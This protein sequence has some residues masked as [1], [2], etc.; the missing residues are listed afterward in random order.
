MKKLYLDRVIAGLEMGDVDDAVLNNLV[1]F[2]EI[3]PM[4]TIRFVHVIPKKKI[5]ETLFDKYGDPFEWM[6]E[7]EEQLVEQTKAKL[8]KKFPKSQV[9]MEL[10]DGDPLEELLDEEEDFDAELLVIGQKADTRKHGILAKQLARKAQSN[11]LIFPEECQLGIAQ[12]MV[13]FDF[14]DNAIWSLNAAVAIAGQAD[15][16]VAIHCVYV[17][18]VPNFSVYRISKTVEEFREIMQR[19]MR[20]RFEE[21]VTSNFKQSA[22]HIVFQTIEKDLP[23]K[24]HYLMDYAEENDVGFV[25]MGA[26]GQS[27]LNRI[28]LGSVTESFLNQND[29]FATMVVRKSA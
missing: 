14:S 23:G 20:S 18:D 3:V 2:S 8:V 22:D 19:S 13:P 9:Q 12:I 7:M 24:A 11:A 5:L 1:K 28:L 25:I 16:P 17:Y 21:I 26:R 6:F 10:E 27:T 15:Q 29:Q 4:K